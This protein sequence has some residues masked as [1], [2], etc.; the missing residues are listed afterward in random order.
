MI[1][2]IC[3]PGRE[4]PRVYLVLLHFCT[5]CLIDHWQVE[6]WKYSWPP[7]LL[8]SKP[9][10]GNNESHT[11]TAERASLY[12]CFSCPDWRAFSVLAVF[13]S[14]RLRESPQNKDLFTPRSNTGSQMDRVAWWIHGQSCSCLF[15][16]LLHLTCLFTNSSLNRRSWIFVVLFRLPTDEFLHSGAL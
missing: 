15:I 5:F 6:F 7:L 4:P 1:L 9:V 12:F 8:F 14:D 16:F 2:L 3:Y 10:I 13:T 11:L